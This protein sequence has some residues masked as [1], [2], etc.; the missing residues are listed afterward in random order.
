MAAA[1]T[2]VGTVPNPGIPAFL[3]VEVAV[4]AAA[5]VPVAEEDEVEDRPAVVLEEALDFV[6]VELE[7]LDPPLLPEDPDEAQ[8]QPLDPEEHFVPELQ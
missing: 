1:K 7:E 6:V 2:A 5:V 3:L 8:V 4:P